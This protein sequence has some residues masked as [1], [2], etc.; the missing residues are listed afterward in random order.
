MAESRT[1]EEECWVET[2]AVRRRCVCG[3]EMLPTEASIRLTAPPTYEHK[4][5]DGCG[6]V[7]WFTERYPTIRHNIGSR[8]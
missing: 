2:Y 7:E 4:C 6:H 1:R 3:G 5:V 8:K